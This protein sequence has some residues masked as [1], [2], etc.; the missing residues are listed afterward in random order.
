MV[1]LS[2]RSM[3]K[4]SR[5]STIKHGIKITHK[6][7]KN[8]L[9]NFWSKLAFLL[10]EDLDKWAKRFNFKIHKILFTKR[11]VYLRNPFFQNRSRQ[12]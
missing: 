12:Q 11:G 10:K 3:K 7:Q 9:E 6:K 8:N 1:A 2:N 4:Y 5:T